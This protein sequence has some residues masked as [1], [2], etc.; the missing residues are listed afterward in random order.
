MNAKPLFFWLTGSLLVLFGAMIAGQARPDILGASTSS[1]IIS[2]VVAFI[3][4][5]VGSLMWITVSGII[6]KY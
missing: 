5:L 1:F 2:I 4:I 3:L 6:N